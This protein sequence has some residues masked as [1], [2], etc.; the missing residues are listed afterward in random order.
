MVWRFMILIRIILG[1]PRG[2]S[3]LPRPARS[4]PARW[5]DSGPER[6]GRARRAAARD[7]VA[8]ATP[9]GVRER[10][11][12]PDTGTEVLEGRHSSSDGRR[13]PR[14]SPPLAA[15]IPA[16]CPCTPRTRTATRDDKGPGI[17]LNPPFF[18]FWGEG[19]SDGGSGHP[20][21]SRA[22]S[23]STRS[24]S[25]SCRAPTSTVG[26]AVEAFA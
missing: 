11:S 21:S 10:A 1:H 12:R 16:G 2:Q 23:A 9:G 25:S 26:T 22:E 8:R 4:R 18:F 3:V 20:D 13:R 6:R 19:G 14:T 7:S 5:G 24:C 17:P 15:E